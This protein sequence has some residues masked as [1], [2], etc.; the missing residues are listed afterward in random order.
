MRS[1]KRLISSVVPKNEEFPIDTYEYRG[2][3]YYINNNIA[4]ASDFTNNKRHASVKA[5]VDNHLHAI[6]KEA[7]FIKQKY[8][9]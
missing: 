1:E 5:M 8:Q 2:V 3:T 7:M 9:Y 6:E 4:D